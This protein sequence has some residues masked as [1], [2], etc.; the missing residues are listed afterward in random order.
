M[1]ADNEV[2]HPNGPLKGG[3]EA[4]SRADVGDGML[5]ITQPEGALLPSTML[6]VAPHPHPM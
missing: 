3:R 5:R 6:H 1:S 2:L 4:G